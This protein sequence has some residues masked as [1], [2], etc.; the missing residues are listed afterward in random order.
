[1]ID[2][3]PLEVCIT[4]LAPD[5]AVGVRPNSINFVEQFPA[6]TANAPATGE[7]HI[8][9]EPN[10]RFYVNTEEFGVGRS[11]NNDLVVDN[12]KISRSH[13]KILIGQDNSYHVQ[14]LGS[15]NGTML[16]G[17]LLEKFQDYHLRARGEIQL[18]GILHMTFTDFGATYVTP[19]ILTVYGLSLSHSDR[20]VWIQ[21]K[22][23]DAFKLSSSEHKFLG[24][25]MENYPNHVTH[26]LLAQALW[27]Y[28]SD[29]ADDEKRSRDALFNIAKRLRD[30]LQV[31]DPDYE[32]IETVRKWG[33]R[34]GGYKFNKH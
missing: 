2:R 3:E 11:I 23:E 18:A 16:D 28:S 10:T 26:A 14:D 1:M 20:T 15:A 17:K 13:L 27:E 24:L 19:E 5:V 6:A 8:K 30:R 12:P 34:Q 33:N 32:Y 4:Y 22:E 31:V 9:L 29:E 7:I 21:G 25:L